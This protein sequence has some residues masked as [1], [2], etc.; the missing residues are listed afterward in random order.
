MQFTSAEVASMLDADPDI[1]PLLDRRY[2]HAYA[3]Y[4]LAR[5]QSCFTYQLVTTNAPARQLTDDS[6][7][8]RPDP[9]YKTRLRWQ[10]NFWYT[11]KK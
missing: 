8:C 4:L 5:A 9:D 3:A 2:V 11:F 10:S 1:S 7:P 6:F